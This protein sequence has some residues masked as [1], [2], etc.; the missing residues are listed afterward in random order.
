MGAWNKHKGRELVATCQLAS[1]GKIIVCRSLDE[2]R[3]RKHC[4][5]R[6]AAL[7]RPPIS[8]AAADRGR[9]LSGRRKREQALAA[10][11]GLTPLQAFQ[12]GYMAG[13]R[14]K[15]TQV[16]RRYLL[17]ARTDRT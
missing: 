15:L 17:V 12:R 4:S 6:C 2:Q 16:R 8:K 14:S 9:A 1:C 3:R 13:L 7:N 5:R 10:V 11:A